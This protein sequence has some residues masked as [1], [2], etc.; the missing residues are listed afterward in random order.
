MGIIKFGRFCKAKT[1][2][3]KRSYMSAK[4]PLMRD[5]SLRRGITAAKVL[6]FFDMCKFICFF[7][8]NLSLREEKSKNLT[9]NQTENLNKILGG[10]GGAPRGKGH[11]NAPTSGK[12]L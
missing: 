11:K 8:Q 4:P 10:R 12:G 1:S 9:K 5:I 3:N 6:L 7:L 2:V